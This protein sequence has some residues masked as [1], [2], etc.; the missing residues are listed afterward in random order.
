MNN[1]RLSLVV[2]TYNEETSLARCLSSVASIVDEIIVTDMGSSD[3][4]IAIAKSFGAKVFSIKW[5]SFV[6]R[7]RNFGVS[8][9]NGRWVLILDPDEEVPKSL[10]TTIRKIILEDK[11]DVINLP[12]KSILYH[13]WMKHTGWWPEYHPRLF[14]K[15]FLE[16]P[17]QIH[18]APMVK[19]RVL[20][21]EALEANAIVHHTTATVSGSL[22]K[23]DRYTASETYFDLKKPTLEEVIKYSQDEFNWRFFDQKGYLDGMRGYVFS[24]YMEFYRFIV[25]VKAWEKKGFPEICSPQHL[26]GV[27]ERIRPVNREDEIKKLR[28]D[29]DKIQKSKFYRLW[30]IYC[31]VRDK[32]TNHKSSSMA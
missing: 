2:N 24:K 21:L 6:E 30:Q 31:G 3:K 8:K 29:L 27:V 26:K 1:T 12:F 4:T 7:A 19:G 9:T 10:L 18:T 13:K 14:R 28:H 22:S 25:F 32:L 17:P 5:Q 20:S 16:C 11:F 15:G 23:I